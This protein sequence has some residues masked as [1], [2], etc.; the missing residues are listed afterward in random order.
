MQ[1]TFVRNSN[2][3]S[4]IHHTAYFYHSFTNDHVSDNYYFYNFESFIIYD[5]YNSNYMLF[6][7]YYRQLCT[8]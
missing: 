3:V 2:S 5:F 7:V 8:T 6:I 1:I 4:Y